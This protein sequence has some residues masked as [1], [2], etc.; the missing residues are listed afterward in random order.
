M[1]LCHAGRQ[2]RPGFLHFPCEV[3]R[4]CALG[5]SALSHAI[6]AGG[7][8]LVLHLNVRPRDRMLHHASGWSYFF[9]EDAT[10]LTFERDSSGRISA[11]TL[12][13]QGDNLQARRI[14][15]SASRADSTG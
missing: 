13:R 11:A 3:D 8:T 1:P 7:D 14:N 4:S 12:G 10:E 6:V 5:D 9:T 2:Q 15:R